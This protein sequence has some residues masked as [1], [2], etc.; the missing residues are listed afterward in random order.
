MSSALFSDARS[1]AGQLSVAALSMRFRVLLLGGALLLLCLVLPAGAF[2]VIHPASVLDGPNNQIL[3]LDGVAM[4]HDGSGGVVYRKDVEDIPHVFVVPFVNG[5]WGHPVEVDHEDPYG[6]SEP[7]IAAAEDG[8][9]LVVWVQLRNISTGGVKEYELMSASLQSGASSFGPATIVDPNVGEPVN[10][11]IRAV[12]PSIA[13]SPSGQAYVVYRVVTNDCEHGDPYT[14]VC[15][16]GKGVEV[17]VAHFNYRTWSSLGAVNRAKQFGM[18]EPTASN[19]PSIGIDQSG[20][21][22][23]AWQE[24][25]ATGVSRI[26]ARR[27]FSATQGNVLQA[28]PETIGGKPVTSNAEAPVVAM[29]PHGEA[30]IAFRIHGE[31]GSAV[32]STQLFVNSINSAFGIGASQLN[33]PVAEPGAASPTLGLPGIGI[34][35]EGDYRVVWPQA[36]IVRELTGNT[37]GSS[38]PVT[39]G[40]TTGER[41]FATVDPAGG[42]VSAWMASSDDGP[43][44]DVRE[45]FPQGQAGSQSGQFGGSIP[46][47]VNGLSFDGS[48]QGDALLGWAVGSP[49]Y[50]EIVGDFV[51]VPPQPFILS[52]VPREWLR[53]G[54]VE[55]GWE[56]ALDAVAGET[57]TVYVDG[58]PLV[59]GITGLSA[60]FS[61]KGLSNGVHRVQV[62][63]TDPAG[64]HELSKVAELKIDADPPV[65]KVALIDRRRGVQVRVSDG[66]SG[67]NAHA[68]MISF[69]DGS[70]AERGAKATHTYKHRGTYVITADVRDETG[71][72]MTVHLRV[73]VA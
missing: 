16:F 59:S 4:T 27:L 52:S 55:I 14:S 32:P 24:P 40:S 13:M 3:E 65:V 29:S 72:S 41:A 73:R 51:Q 44:V 1:L 63:A 49:G 23:V 18:P 37:E 22:L 42:G 50:V 7:A 21:G 54:T 15:G 39:I 2:A 56:P 43:A 70:R 10:G 9:L 6:A 35:T 61:T 64:Q 31:A 30:R 66:A 34:D 33:G 69:G 26:W 46:G 68:T 47:P 48:S 53:P 62:L 67:V 17:R 28:S 5:D 38:V 36:G 58:R 60:K 71:L 8:D 11:D 25:D 19:A 20:E 57:Y 45:D 12:D